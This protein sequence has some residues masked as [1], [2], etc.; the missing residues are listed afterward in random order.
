M[1]SIEFYFMW[2]KWQTEQV[3]LKA[4]ARIYLFP[5]HKEL[6]SGTDTHKPSTLSSSNAVESSTNESIHKIN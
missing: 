6:I 3:R 5:K 4:K 2:L 1:Y